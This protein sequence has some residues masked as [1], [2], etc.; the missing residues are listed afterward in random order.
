MQR[1]N[2]PGFDTLLTESSIYTCTFTLGYLLVLFKRQPLCVST[3]M[4]INDDDDYRPHVWGCDAMTS[5]PGLITDRS[6]FTTR[7]QPWA[8]RPQRRDPVRE[9]L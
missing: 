9:P 6:S 7:Q 2:S 8:S 1:Q 4:L 5:S 3:F